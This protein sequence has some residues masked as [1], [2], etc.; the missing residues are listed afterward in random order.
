M[1]NEAQTNRFKD[2]PWFPQTEE[3]TVIG[4]AGGIG[5]WLAFFLNRAGFGTLMYDFDTIET[6]NLGGQLF[7]QEDVGTFK[8]VAVDDIIHSF[9]GER[10]HYKIEKFDEETPTHRFMFSAFDNMAAR[11]A[12]FEVWKKSII[13]ATV[14]PVFIDGRLELEQLQIFAVTPDTMDKYEQEHLFNDSEVPDAPCTMRQSSHTAAMIASSMVGIFTNHISN[15]YLG[16]KIRTVPF[17]YEVLIPGM[18]TNI[19]V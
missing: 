19:E 6:H 5:S 11:K 4:G 13:N 3:L 2:A 18:L 12:M 17:K 1:I 7:R 8:C 14:T 10:I 15:I 9:T 16:H